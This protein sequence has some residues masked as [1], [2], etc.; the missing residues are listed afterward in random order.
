MDIL[1]LLNGKRFLG[2]EFLTW[3]WYVS[4][5]EGAVNLPQGKRVIVLLGD[6][7]VLGPAQG[8]EGSLI[9]VRGRDVSLAEAR[10]ALK[11]GKL[12]DGLHLGLELDGEEYWMNL[13]ASDLGVS[14]LKVPP[15]AQKVDDGPEAL[16]LERVALIGA[17][18]GALDGLFVH[19]LW[20]R[21]ADEGKGMAQMLG[22]WA[23][24]AA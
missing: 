17:V 13:R 4:E 21:T 10:A 14:S 5:E 23:S 6:R 18:L 24:E 2:Q 1:D 12:V 22:Y 7:L 9:A 20:F 8:Q 11:Q 3:L 15:V 16:I 19:F